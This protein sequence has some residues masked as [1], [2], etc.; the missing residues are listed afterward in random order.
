MSDVFWR[1]KRGWRKKD[2]ENAMRKTSSVCLFWFLLAIP[3][4]G[5]TGKFTDVLLEFSVKSQ[6]IVGQGYMML[7]FVS[8]ATKN[9]YI[10][11]QGINY[12]NINDEPWEFDGYWEYINFANQEIRGDI[13]FY[14]MR[15]GS[16]YWYA[17]ATFEIIKGKMIVK[18]NG[19][20][21]SFKFS[22]AKLPPGLY[23]GKPFYFSAVIDEDN[24]F[25]EGEIY[26]DYNL[27]YFYFRADDKTVFE[28]YVFISQKG[29]LCGTGLLSF[30][31]PV[32][33][34]DARANIVGKFSKE[35]NIKVKCKFEEM[36]KIKSF[37]T[38]MIL[39]Q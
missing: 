8:S 17:E 38:T 20:K 23:N 36:G 27:F 5:G 18:S 30:K 6:F 14:K 19:E 25:F 13:T 1:R 26:F 2:K 3:A 39:D 11:G 34:Y 4:F 29:N 15:E 12:K 35:N 7:D 31:A 32:E 22:E 16:S 24:K 37:S 21:A 9:N 10:S 33:I 28:G